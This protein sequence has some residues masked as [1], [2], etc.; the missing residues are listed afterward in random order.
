MICFACTQRTPSQRERLPEFKKQG[1][2]SENGIVREFMRVRDQ[3]FRQ[4]I[5]VVDEQTSFLSLRAQRQKIIYISMTF[6]YLIFAWKF[7]TRFTNIDIKG[8]VSLELR[9]VAI[10]GNRS[11]LVGNFFRSN[12]TPSRE[13]HKTIFHNFT[14]FAKATTS[15]CDFKLLSWCCPYKMAKKCCRLDFSHQTVSL[16]VLLNL[17]R[18]WYI[19]SSTKM[20]NFKVV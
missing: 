14:K 1:E 13:E 20:A 5:F 3:K 12:W 18:N 4:S 16:N 8:T 6:P 11:G 7:C 2:T 19:S 9:L 17:Q 15:L 10:N